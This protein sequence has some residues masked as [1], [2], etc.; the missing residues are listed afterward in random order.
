MIECSKDFPIKRCNIRSEIFTNNGKTLAY[1]L[2]STYLRF[3]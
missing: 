2:I 3:T 1:M